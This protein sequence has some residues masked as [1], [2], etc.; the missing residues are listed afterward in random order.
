MNKSTLVMTSLGVALC[1]SLL[2]GLLCFVFLGKT[3]GSLN[4]TKTLTKPLSH[5]QISAIRIPQ[6]PDTVFVEMLSDNPR[7]M[8]FHN[9]L[10]PAE[11]QQ[12]IQLAE[13]RMAPSTVQLEKL[14]TV[15]DRTSYTTNLL[16]HETDVVKQVESR[17]V[18]FA[19]YPMDHL[20]PL[21]VVR[22]APNQF[23]KPHFDYFEKGKRGT[24]EA[25]ARGG[26][27]T[28]TMFVYLNTLP[29]EETGG[30]T[31]FPELKLRIKPKAGTAVYFMNITPD[32]QDDP[33]LLH[34]G[35]PP[36]MS[37]KY[38]LNIW[39]RQKPFH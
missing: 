27:R 2:I 6:L 10:S 25:L 36:T 26:Q 21:Q 1:L 33:R 35:E 31:I 39:F 17:A 14:A 30:S 23:Y 20:E 8:I 19:N 12:L 16:K 34:G 29:A 38:G 4:Q 11:C 28:V 22:Y 24:K 13:P 3:S 7:V 5:K 15:P 32:G 9:F 18:M 37:T